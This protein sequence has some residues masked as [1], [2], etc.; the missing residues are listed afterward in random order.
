[1]FIATAIIIFVILV[2]IWAVAALVIRVISILKRRHIRG[3]NTACDRGDGRGVRVS[4]RSENIRTRRR[5]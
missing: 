1:M 2:G 3:R 5:C 4:R